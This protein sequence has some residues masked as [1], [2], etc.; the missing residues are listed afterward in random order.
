MFFQLEISLLKRMP[1]DWPELEGKAAAGSAAPPRTAQPVLPVAIEPPS[2][3]AR[4]Y[5]SSKDWDV[6]SRRG[7][8]AICFD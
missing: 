2:K 5:S 1:G 3:V 7:Y 8:Q 4:P 6:V